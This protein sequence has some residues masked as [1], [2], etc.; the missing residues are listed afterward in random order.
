MSRASRPKDR[1]S[2]ER[3]E[4]RE[5]PATAALANGV[6]TISGSHDGETIDVAVAPA[7]RSGLLGPFARATETDADGRSFPAGGATVGEA[8]TFSR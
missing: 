2:V 8:G 5:V 1:L 4:Q 6:L 7:Q 3:L